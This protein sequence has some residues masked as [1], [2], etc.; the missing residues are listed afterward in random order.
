MKRLLLAAARLY[1]RDWRDRYGEEFD[2]LLD[3]LAPRWRDVVDITAG[4]LVMHMSRLAL[5]PL[6]LAVAGG[7]TGAA[8]SFATAPVYASSSLVH[9]QT[10]PGGTGGAA[11]GT[12]V[13]ATIETALAGT[14]VD[15]KAIA[16]TVREPGTSGPMLLEVTGSASSARAAQQ[17]TERVVAS[18]IEAN[19]TA[20]EREPRDGRSSGVLFRIVEAATL[21][22]APQ[23]ETAGYAATGLVLGAVAGAMLAFAQRRRR[24][25]HQS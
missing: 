7:L 12:H 8:A 5:V 18:I 1:P 23:R 24:P 2:A 4:A 14:T 13:Q 10:P 3:D 25:A 11:T 17:A 21:P 15:R 20:A 19:L 6:A 22:G 16:V 9:V